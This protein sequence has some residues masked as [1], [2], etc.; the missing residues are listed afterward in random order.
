MLQDRQFDQK[1]L[2]DFFASNA[3]QF[4]SD[5]Y[6]QIARSGNGT[7]EQYT[8]KL[9]KKATVAYEMDGQKLK[10]LVIGYTHDLPENGYSY[11]AYVIVSPE[12]RG[13]G[14]MRRLL[15]EYEAFCKTQGIPVIWLQTGKTNTTAQ[16][17]YEKCGFVSKG[18]DSERTIRY[19]KAVS[20]AK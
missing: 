6:G 1:L 12:Y 2:F 18:A 10:G 19:E 9:S 14:V 20:A 4:S 11:I 5:L 15:E 8:E 3:D 17:A 7:L 13:Q 16:I